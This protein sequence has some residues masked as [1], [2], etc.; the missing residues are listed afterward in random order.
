[1]ESELSCVKNYNIAVKKR[2]DSITFLRRIV[3]GAAD[4]SYGIEV[5]KLAGIPNSVVNRAREVLT[6]I[7]EGKELE[8]PKRI[9]NEESDFGQ[10]SLYSYENSPLMKA[11]NDIDVETLTPIEALNKLYELKNL[12][13]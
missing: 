11:L 4:E 9:R 10:I 5:A 1:M 12:L 2:G 7:D 13:N 6:S 8:V 3:K